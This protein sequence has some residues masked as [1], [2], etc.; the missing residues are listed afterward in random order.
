MEYLLKKYANLVVV[1]FSEVVELSMAAL[2]L[3]AML[4]LPPHLLV[5]L[6]VLNN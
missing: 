2:P 4:A 5:S 3:L 1:I 6:L